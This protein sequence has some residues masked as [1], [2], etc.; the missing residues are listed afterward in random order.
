MVLLTEFL[1][2]KFQILGYV[3]KLV[4]VISNTTDWGFTLFVNFVKEAG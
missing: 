4:W 1:Q 2:L 3:P